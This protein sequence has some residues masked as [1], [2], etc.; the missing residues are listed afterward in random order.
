M[1]G[2]PARATDHPVRLGQ[3]SHYVLAFLVLAF[4]QV[5]VSRASCSLS[6]AL[7]SNAMAFSSAV[8]IC[9]ATCAMRSDSSSRLCGSASTRIDSDKR[10]GHANAVG[11]ITND[12]SRRYGLGG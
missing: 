5:D 8:G 9:T 1:I 6:A 11:S 4:L 10:S 3:G 7:S 12:C 2:R